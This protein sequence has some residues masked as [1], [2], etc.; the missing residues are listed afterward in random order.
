MIFWLTCNLLKIDAYSNDFQKSFLAKNPCDWNQIRSNQVTASVNALNHFHFQFIEKISKIITK[1]PASTLLRRH[2][3]VSLIYVPPETFLQRV[4]LVSL[5]YVP[6][7]RSQIGRFYSRTSEMLMMSQ[8]GP[9]R[10]YWS[11]KWINFIWVLDSTFFR[12]LRSFSLIKVPAS[13]SVQRL[14]ASVSFRY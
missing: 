13:T 9:W 10:K 6:V 11:L 12:H 2:K 7:M 4:K 1:T 5:T 3:D 8:H 14:K